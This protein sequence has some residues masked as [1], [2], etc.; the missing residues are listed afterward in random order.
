[1]SRV[2]TG[3]ETLINE[4]P[5]KIRGARIGVVCHPASVDAELRHA[6]DLLPATGARIAAIFGPEHGA[7]GEA[8]DMEDVGD[9]ALDPRLGVPV[10]SLYGATFA[11]LTPRREQLE[12]LDALVIDLQDVGARYYTFVWTMALCM[13]AAGQVGVRVLVCDR[14]NPIDGVTT[15]GNLI[16]PGFES[17][18]GLHPLPN[19]HGLTAGEIARH[20]QKRRGIRCELEVLPM[21]GWRREMYFEDTGLPWIYPSPNMPTVDTAVVY[22]GMCLVEATEWSEGRGTCRPFEIA[23]APGIDPEALAAELSRYRLPGCRFRPLYFRPK[24]QKQAERT[25]GGVQIHLTD[26]ARF[27]SYLTG[28]AFLQSVKRVAPEVFAW[29]AKPYEFVADIPAIDLLAGDDQLRLA[30]EAD[31]DLG[32]LAAQWAQERAAFE[33]VRREAFLYSVNA[34]GSDL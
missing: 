1:M 5:E 9:L 34:H 24:F 12:G 17:F 3:L 14:P 31:A 16:K 27:D 26:R 15:E 7:R 22:P 6:L 4:C 18:V 19:R 29:R 8:Q 32:D 20:V 25:C 10:H 21:R 2:Q 11:S 28:A 33:E 13:E 30:L 23:G